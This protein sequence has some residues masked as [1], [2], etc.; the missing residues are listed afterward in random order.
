LLGSAAALPQARPV[1]ESRVTGLAAQ[2]Y[3]DGIVASS[4]SM[5][6][7]LVFVRG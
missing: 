4:F 7:L 6:F 1:G 2:E 3:L 5:L